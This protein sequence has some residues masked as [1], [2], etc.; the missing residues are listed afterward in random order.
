MDALISFVLLS[1]TVIFQVI[2]I[3]FLGDFANTTLFTLTQWFVSLLFGFLSMP[4]AAAIK[5][6][7]TM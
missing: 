1:C 4:V 2:I 7:P 3:E 5:M 6:I